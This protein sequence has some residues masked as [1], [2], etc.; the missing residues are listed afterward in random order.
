MNSTCSMAQE[1]HI[2]F[3]SHP[4]PTHIFHQL[5]PLFLQGL[6]LTESGT[7]IKLTLPCSVMEEQRVSV[8]A[9][10]VYPSSSSYQA[11]DRL[12]SPC[13]QGTIMP[14]SGEFFFGDRS[15]GLLSSTFTC[16]YA[17]WIDN[18]RPS[19]P[20]LP[21]EPSYFEDPDLD[22]FVSRTTRK[23][24]RR[25]SVMLIWGTFMYS[26]CHSRPNPDHQGDLLHQSEP[27]PPA[28]LK[29]TA[30][31]QTSTL[32]SRGRRR[33]LTIVQ[34]STFTI[35]HRSSSCGSCAWRMV[36]VCCWGTSSPFHQ[37][38]ERPSIFRRKV[39]LRAPVVILSCQPANPCL[40]RCRLPSLPSLSLPL[41]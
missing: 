34:R 22:V 17:P 24:R 21:S 31:H 20:G 6:G 5:C 19:F 4:H 1:R 10:W 18:E 39:P 2:S 14:R 15:V 3:R 37:H 36:L 32:V 16:S 29:T 35:S 23:M 11:T 38:I 13:T 40:L 9:R 41:L 25:I 33:R 30:P 26:L 12:A 7:H 28:L 27:N 8:A